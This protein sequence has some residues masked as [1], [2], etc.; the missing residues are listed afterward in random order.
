MKSHFSNLLENFFL[1]AFFH[2]S[3]GRIIIRKILFLL[4][5]F[6]FN[7]LFIASMTLFISSSSTIEKRLQ[8]KKINQQ[9]RHDVHDAE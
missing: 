5:T 9:Q 1:S 7:M 4:L 2:H 6:A 8:Q 3:I